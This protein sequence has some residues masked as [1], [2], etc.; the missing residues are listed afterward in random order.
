MI[1]L[2]ALKYLK[3][4]KKEQ[5]DENNNII[6]YENNNSLSLF[7]EFI[8]SL[9]ISIWAAYI[10][11]NCNINEPMSVRLLIT[12]FAFLFGILYLIYYF[13]LYK[14]LGSHCSSKSK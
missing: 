11:Y 10:A 12:L 7:L 3:Y 6:I 1:E 2:F 4:K 9:T 13:V 8:I 5:F 14:L